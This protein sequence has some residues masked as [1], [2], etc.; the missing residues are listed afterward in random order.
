MLDVNLFRDGADLEPIKKSQRMRCSVVSKE[1]AL[2]AAKKKGDKKEIAAAE[3]ALAKGMERQNVS[4]DAV[5][6]HRTLRSSH[7]FL[8]MFRLCHPATRGIEPTQHTAW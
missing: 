4:N 8:D 5:L 1:K 2:A 6:C 7:H 3:E